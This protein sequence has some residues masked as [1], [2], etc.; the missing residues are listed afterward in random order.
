MSDVV[1]QG[2]TEDL[3]LKY[4]FDSACEF[5][6]VGVR[7]KVIQQLPWHLGTS[8]RS[9]L[10]DHRFQIINTS[11]RAS[12][13]TGC[14]RKNLQRK[15]ALVWCK[16]KFLVNKTY[17]NVTNEVLAF[18]YRLF[19]PIWMLQ[20]GD[21]AIFPKEVKEPIV[22]LYDEWLIIHNRRIIDH[23]G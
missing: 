12:G 22:P 15:S 7:T 20:S 18:E 11:T 13:Y 3:P 1:A 16:L 6:D 14:S 21:I 23:V 5:W 19:Q 10:M 9:V 17:I 8:A 4:Y 2:A